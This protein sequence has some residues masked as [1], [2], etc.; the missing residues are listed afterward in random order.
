LLEEYEHKSGVFDLYQDQ[1]N[2]YWLR[3]VIS[4]FFNLS[5]MLLGILLVRK[6]MRTLGFKQKGK[7]EREER[8]FWFG[9]K[10]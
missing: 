9:R 5:A 10:G 7:A 6:I 2:S 8:T 4:W 3:V 1:V